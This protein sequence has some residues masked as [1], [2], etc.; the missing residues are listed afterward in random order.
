M[1]IFEKAGQSEDEIIQNMSKLYK[2][3]VVLDSGAGFLALLGAALAPEVPG[4]AQFQ[5]M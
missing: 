3:V 2:N 5:L 4:S 1:Y